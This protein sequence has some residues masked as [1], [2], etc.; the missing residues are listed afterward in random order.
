MGYAD[1]EWGTGDTN[2]APKFAQQIE[3]TN[4]LRIAAAVEPR[5]IGGEPFLSRGVARDIDATNPAAKLQILLND[6]LVHESTWFSP[7]V[8]W[9]SFS[10]FNRSVGAVP[11]FKLATL[12]LRAIARASSGGAEIS[13]GAVA[14][15][16]FFPTQDHELFSLV[17]SRRL[18]ED[19]DAYD[20]ASQGWVN[21]RIRG[22]AA[23]THRIPIGIITGGV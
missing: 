6:A 10:H 17:T 9:G 15:I 7:S 11:R 2:T 18:L 3:N 4:V 14:L 5:W 1:V 20:N 21:V 13:L 8:T 12:E 23:F 22:L 16:R 19:R